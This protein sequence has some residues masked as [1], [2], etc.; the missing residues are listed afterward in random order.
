MVLEAGVEAE[1]IFNVAL[2][3]T[4]GQGIETKEV[5]L[6]DRAEPVTGLGG[7]Q[8]V[9]PLHLVMLTMSRAFAE[10]EEKTAAARCMVPR[11]IDSE[12]QANG[13]LGAYCVFKS[14]VRRLGHVIEQ[15]VLDCQLLSVGK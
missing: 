3:E 15:I 2:I 11:G 7:N 10:G 12:I 13:P 4:G 8:D 5:T 1:R 9:A 14:N 6:K